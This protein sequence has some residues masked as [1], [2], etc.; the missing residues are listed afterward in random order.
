M[1]KTELVSRSADDGAI[2]EMRR[3]HYDVAGA[4]N[5]G[6]LVSLLKLVTVAQ[7]LFGTDF[8]PGGS[9]ADVARS[10]AAVGFSEAD[11][12][13]ID[14]DNALKLLPRFAA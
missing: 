11:M 5:A 2:A 9:S 14:R 12:R 6:A 7:V 3:F 4:A 8:P 10:L 13:A 1:A